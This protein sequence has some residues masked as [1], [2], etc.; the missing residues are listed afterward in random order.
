MPVDG[1]KRAGKS[2]VCS[3]NSQDILLAVSG[4]HVMQQYAYKYTAFWAQLFMAF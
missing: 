2:D 1:V 4:D 3:M